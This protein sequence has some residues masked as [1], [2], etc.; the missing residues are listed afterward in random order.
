MADLESRE[1]L[2][3]G[4]TK[5]AR[6]AVIGCPIRHS[7]SPEMHQPALD[8]A[9]VDGRYIRLEV[10]P[11][12][13]GK[14]ISRM[15]ELGFRGCNITVP[16]KL[17]AM[18]F[19]D[20]IHPDAQIIGAVNTLVFSD[21]GTVGF[22]TDGP[23]FAAAVEEA[24]GIPLSNLSV[25]IVGAGG[26][27]GQAI[28]TQCILL[29]VERLV[30]I[31]RSPEKLLPMVKRL[32]QLGPESEIIAIPLNEDAVASHCKSCDLIVNTSSLGLHPGD[33]SILPPGC[34]KA[35][36]LVYDTIYKPAMSP[37]LV[38]AQAANCRISNGLSMLIHQ[39][40]L[41]FQQWYPGTSPLPVMRFAMSQEAGFSAG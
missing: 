10:A 16:H 40:A 33:R 41:A 6:L 32:M 35:D 29:G 24:F 21:Q 38:A 31:N 18:A 15:R 36:H 26:G 7:A 25:A 37:L 17:E 23:G 30:L 19:C 13:V 20:E 22:N 4:N 3:E 14:A 11:G 12:Q 1:V 28:A 2:D 27:A 34:F 39:G 9:N 5:P 8:A